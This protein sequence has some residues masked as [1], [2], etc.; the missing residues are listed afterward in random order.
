MNENTLKNKTY[1]P[2]VSFSSPWPHGRFLMLLLSQ[3]NRFVFID[4]KDKI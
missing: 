4:V 2:F 3:H 1:N